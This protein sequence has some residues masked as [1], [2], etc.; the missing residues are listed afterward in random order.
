MVQEKG[1]VVP[2]PLVMEREVALRVRSLAVPGLPSTVSTAEPAA[3][4]PR[5][6]PGVVAMLPLAPAE[7]LM[8][9][10]PVM[11]YMRSPRV[12]VPVTARVL[13]G[14][15]CGADVAGEGEGVAG[16]KI[17]LAGGIG[18]E[19]QERGGRGG[20]A[21]DAAGAVAG[22]EG[23]VEGEVGDLGGEGA[24]GVEVAGHGDVGGG[25]GDGEGAQRNGQVLQDAGDDV[26]V[27]IDAES[28]D[29]EAVGIDELVEAVELEGAVAGVGLR[30]VVLEDE[31]A[32]A[33]DGEVAGDAGD[34]AG[35]VVEVAGDG[36]L[37][38]A[39]ADL[40]GVGAAEVAVGGA[41]VGEALGELGFEIHAG[42]FEADGVDV[43]DVVADD[44]EFGLVAGESG[45]P[46]D[47]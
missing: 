43:G 26:V 7:V 23:L 44:V 20:R 12:V 25:V 28:L 16:L 35:A 29:V 13:A 17:E 22:V 42:G 36:T 32:V 38:D 2:A 18:H 31:E 27:G 15:W 33:L 39:H 6:T 4:A 8:P 46:G 37:D 19:G 10:V 21:G 3:P 14:P 45:K 41:A 30:G 34:F 11:K 1:V 40:Q 47:Q 24:V 9:R 5:E